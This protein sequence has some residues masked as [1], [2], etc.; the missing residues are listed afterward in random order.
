MQSI[1]RFAKIAGFECGEAFTT[2]TF[3]SPNSRDEHLDLMSTH[4]QSSFRH[5]N[6]LSYSAEKKGQCRSGW[7]LIV[8]HIA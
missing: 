6:T 7:D 5:D 2:P 1:K 8:M 4:H 3:Q